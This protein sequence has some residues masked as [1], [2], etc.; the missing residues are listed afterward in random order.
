[1]VTTVEHLAAAKQLRLTVTMP[2]DLPHGIGDAH[3]L[4]QVLFNLV[5][6]AI[7]YTEVGEVGLEVAAS[8][9]TFTLVVRDTGPGIAAED[10]QRIFEAFQQGES[11][12]TRTQTGDRPGP[13][14]CQ[15]DYCAA[16]GPTSGSGRV[17]D[18]ARRSGARSR[19][20][21][22]LQGRGP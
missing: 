14:D 12:R 2:A 7:A 13:G 3:R 8:D 9:D 10:Q 6:N 21:S 15:A 20:G 11:A 1:M 18:R 5:G 22:H 16:W 17:R 4:T 19:C